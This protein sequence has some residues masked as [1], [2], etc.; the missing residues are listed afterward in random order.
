MFASMILVTPKETVSMLFSDSKAT[1]YS[2]GS[3][4]LNYNVIETLDSFLN[5]DIIG[6]V[7][8]ARSN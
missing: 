1:C 4:S 2:F 3:V 8:P 7:C 5:Y 6:L